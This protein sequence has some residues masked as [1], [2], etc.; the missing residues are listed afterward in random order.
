MSNLLNITI[1]TLNNWFVKYNYY[2]V[3]NIQL[4]SSDYDKNK[5]EHKST[6]KTK[7]INLIIE[8]VNN[9]NGCSLNDISNNKK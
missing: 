7:Y 9:N 3:N 4:T 2:Y 6:K 1:C 8:Y 5:N